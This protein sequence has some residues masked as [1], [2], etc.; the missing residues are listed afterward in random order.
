MKQSQKHIIFDLDGTIFDTEF[1][2]SR[3]TATLAA[4]QGAALPAEEVFQRF[5]GLGCDDKF[6]GIAASCG[7]SFDKAQLAQLEK[8]HESQKQD[9]YHRE[10][11]P[12][13]PGVPQVLAA[14]EAA[15]DVL[16]IGS[17]NPSARSRLGLGKENLLSYFGDRIYGPDLVEGRK[18]PDPAVFLLAMKENGS[19]PENTVVIEDTEPGIVAGRAAGVFVIAYLDPRF[20]TGAAALEKEKSFRAA[21]ADVVVRDFK[22]VLQNLPQVK[23]K[24]ASFQAKPKSGFSP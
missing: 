15:G 16:S 23:Q 10:H 8:E 1:E 9:I 2:V 11:L 21:G 18:K 7:L 22:D 12:V 3:I 20:G 19:N 5:A 24:T 17:S 14:L 13:V 6:S 4:E